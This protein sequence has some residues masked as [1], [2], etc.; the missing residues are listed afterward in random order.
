VGSMMGSL[1]RI[2]TNIGRRFRPFYVDAEI[3]SRLFKD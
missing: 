1:K 2:I 3:K